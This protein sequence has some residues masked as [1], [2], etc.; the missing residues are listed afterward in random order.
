MLCHIFHTSICLF[1]SL[2]YLSNLGSIIVLFV[3]QIHGILICDISAAWS[4]VP[5][6]TSR[7][8]LPPTLLG[9]WW[10]SLWCM[11]SSMPSQ[12]CCTWYL[13]AFL[14]PSFWP[15]SRV[16]SR[17]S[18]SKS[19]FISQYVKLCNMFLNLFQPTALLRHKLLHM[20]NN[21]I[22]IYFI[23]IFSPGIFYSINM[24]HT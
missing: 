21:K 13:P 11:C 16:T 8:L 2:P 7:W 18:C 20:S 6:H 23:F 14:P 10:P 15:L 22:F 24:R 12:P 1:S 9:C 4:V 17:L 19:S 3:Q 5:T